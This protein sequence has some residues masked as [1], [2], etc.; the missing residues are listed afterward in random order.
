MSLRFSRRLFLSLLLATAIACQSA[1]TKNSGEIVIGMISYGEGEQLL[2]QYTGFKSY[3]GEKTKAW[4]EIEP[5][6]SENKAMERIHNHAWSL[7]FAPPGIAAIAIADYHYLPLFPLQEVGNLRSILVVRD[8]SPI[9]E[10]NEL[11]GKTVVLGQPGSAT[12]YYLPIYNLY[13]LTLAQVLFAPTPKTV[14]ELIAQGKAEA[15]A[16][17]MAEFRLY[18][19][20]FSHV[21]FRVLFTDPHQVPPG[22]VLIEPKVEKSRQQQIRQ[23][24]NEAPLT[25]AQSVGYTSS[26][27]VPD[28]QYMILV[29]KRVR[30]IASHLHQKPVR[31]F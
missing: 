24:M 29:V 23:V 21:K 15:G 7:V 17:S 9:R 6:F 14:L 30:A 22:V 12:G 16:L 8:N 18:S 28:Y 19:S 5:A 31:L 2:N 11:Q 13:G 20:Q 27:A 26:R 1:S 25:I 4:I 10:L 3:L